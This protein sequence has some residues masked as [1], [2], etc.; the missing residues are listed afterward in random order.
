MQRTKGEKIEYLSKIRSSGQN[1]PFASGRKMRA[2]RTRLPEKKYWGSWNS[3]H[4]TRMERSS[5]YRGENSEMKIGH[6]S[7][8]QIGFGTP[9]RQKTARKRVRS[10]KRSCQTSPP[11]E[12]LR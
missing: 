2:K 3:A 10:Q 8:A 5:L 11:K 6:D 9:S 1:N 7:R 4:L 12:R